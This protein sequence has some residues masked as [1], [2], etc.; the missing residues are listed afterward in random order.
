[1]AKELRCSEVGFAC[2]TVLRGEDEDDVMQQAARHGQEA[3]G[4]SEDDLAEP[5]LSEKIR[6]S[7]HEAA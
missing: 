5:S 3:H 1:V 6:S 4:L 7:I 2:D